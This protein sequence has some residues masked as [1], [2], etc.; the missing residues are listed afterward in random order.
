VQS[1]L[2][3]TEENLSSE[4]ISAKQ[5]YSM[6]K[7]TFKRFD[8]KKIA[9]L[10]VDDYLKARRYLGQSVMDDDMES[11]FVAVDMSRSGY[12]DVNEFVYSVM[13]SQ[14]T[15]V[16]CL[17]YL[18]I[19]SKLVSVAARRYS[20]LKQSA[21]HNTKRLVYQPEAGVPDYS[22]E[23][24]HTRALKKE[25]RRS[26]KSDQQRVRLNARKMVQR[27]TGF[28]TSTA[29]DQMQARNQQRSTSVQ[30]RANSFTSGLLDHIMHD[31]H[32]YRG[33]G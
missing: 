11:A 17:A 2:M 14:A 13:G 27:M 9:L 25:E 19:I 31:S 18:K 15:K 24:T 16:G 12:I 6:L 21:E 26:S 29:Y 8:L 3:I 7:D 28:G 10:D 5:R 23:P 22:P 4:F 1:L 20:L 33:T 32:N 30:R